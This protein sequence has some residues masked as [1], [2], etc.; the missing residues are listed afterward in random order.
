MAQCKSKG[1]KAAARRKTGPG[2]V[3]AK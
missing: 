2:R 3:R 1:A